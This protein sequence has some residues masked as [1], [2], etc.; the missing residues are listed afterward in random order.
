VVVAALIEPQ[1]APMSVADVLVEQVNDAAPMP[2]TPELFE[3]P[4]VTATARAVPA[5]PAVN[6]ACFA[7]RVRG[8]G[9]VE[10]FPST[11]FRPGQEVIVYFELDRLQIRSAADGHTTGIDSSFCLVDSA[12]QRVGQWSF[13]PIFE[14][15]P[16]PRRD[17]FARYFLRIPEDAKPGRHRLEWSVTDTV[18]GASRQAHLDLD[19]VTE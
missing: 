5:G 4:T 18:A 6:N 14:T 17:Y 19:V 12:G 10:R 7:T 8:W 3:P 1:S 13:E 9:N 2:P 15:C 11:T 16:A